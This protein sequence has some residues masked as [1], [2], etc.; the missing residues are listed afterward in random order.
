MNAALKWKKFGLAVK[1]Q[2]KAKLLRK[3][4]FLNIKKINN[5]I[6]FPKDICLIEMLY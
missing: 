5:L 1:I 3:M 4:K 6:I 2:E